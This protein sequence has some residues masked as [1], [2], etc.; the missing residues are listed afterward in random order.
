[1]KILISSAFG[2]DRPYIKTN[3]S[4]NRKLFGF[5]HVQIYSSSTTLIK[6][7]YWFC[8]LQNNLYLQNS[9]WQSP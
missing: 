3:T 6:E 8:D 1:M 2:I 7:T 9:G 4:L 5:R